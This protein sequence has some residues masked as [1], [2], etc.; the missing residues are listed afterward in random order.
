MVAPRLWGPRDWVCGRVAALLGANIVEE[1]HNYHN[2][3]W[4]E[5]H[6]GEE[7]WV[8][9]KGATPPSLTEGIRWRHDGGECCNTSRRG[10]RRV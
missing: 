7:L 1:V 9:R 8:M 5:E 4:L 2:H 3:A 10:E 6:N